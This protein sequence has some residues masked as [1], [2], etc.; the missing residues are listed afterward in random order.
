MERVATTMTFKEFE[1]LPDEPGKCELLE[2]EL[3]QLPPAVRKHMQIVHLIYHILLDAVAAIR[4]QGAGA[5][6]GEVYMEMGYRL[7]K[8]TW[9][10]PDV[11]ITYPEQ[12]NGKY[13]ERG[14]LLAV[15]VVSESNT[16]KKMNAKVAAYL[17]AG[18]AEVWVIYPKTRRMLKHRP[19]QP[20][21]TLTE[22]ITSDLLPGVAIDSAKLLE[23]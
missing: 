8:R 11:S 23:V 14:P 15:E 12:P 19:N 18:T 16:A 6:I 13:F 1:R 5:R 17:A 7:S 3:I 10:Q 21:E 4:T 2:G 20:V 22:T 9:L